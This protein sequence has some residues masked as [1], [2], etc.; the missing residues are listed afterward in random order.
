LLHVFETNG[1]SLPEKLGVFSPR[2][3]PTEAAL[4]LLAGFRVTGD[5]RFLAAGADQLAHARALAAVSGALPWPGDARVSSK[6][7]QSRFALGFYVAFK[8]T[9]RRD[10]LLDADRALAVLDR[11][12][13]L[14]T[15][16]SA[17]G[18]RFM[19]PAAIVNGEELVADASASIDPNQDTSVGL[20]Y[21]LA[22][23]EPASAFFRSESSKAQAFENLRAAVDVMHSDG[24]LPLA[25]TPRWRDALDTSYAWWTFYQLHE[26]N[27][28]WRDPHLAQ[29]I[30][31]GYAY[32][33]PALIAGRSI[34]AYP[35]HYDGPM[36]SPEEAWLALPL[37]SEIGQSGDLEA[38]CAVLK[39]QFAA[40]E[41]W[42]DTPGGH[43]WG[44]S[45]LR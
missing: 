22:Y 41:L 7:G 11:F 2:H 42:W 26:A 39:E 3:Y 12:P 21:S 34:R 6:N 4:G 43:T 45:L 23:H 35:T 36:P 1:R 33:R 9:Q 40:P 32:L 44:A 19:L 5:A 17:T 13:R 31:R 25:D 28:L 10:Y 20:A 8:E 24:F 37:A 38:V 14:E 30:G 18:R 16:S 29:R 27:T 15:T